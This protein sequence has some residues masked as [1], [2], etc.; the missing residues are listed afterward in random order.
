MRR[1]MGFFMLY[2]LLATQAWAQTGK[3]MVIFA[4]S[5]YYNGKILTVDERFLSL[6]PL[7]CATGKSWLWETMPRC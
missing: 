1:Q 6:R 4:D 5:V 3:G 7:P 2:C